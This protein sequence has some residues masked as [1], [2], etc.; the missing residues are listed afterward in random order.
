MK[1][2]VVAFVRRLWRQFISTT[3]GQNAKRKYPHSAN[4]VLNSSTPDTKR[5]MSEDLSWQIHG[6]V[7]RSVLI[8]IPNFYRILWADRKALHPLDAVDF[9]CIHLR[10][11]RFCMAGAFDTSTNLLRDK[12]GKFEV[13]ITLG[14]RKK[15]ERWRKRHDVTLSL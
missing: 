5:S 1:R 10:N 14:I 9:W 4:E 11:A 13:T 15:S 3:N 8:G 12:W 7:V 6:I 2:Y